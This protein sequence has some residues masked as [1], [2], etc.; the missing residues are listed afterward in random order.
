MARK[1]IETKELFV[2]ML[3]G[4]VL[5]P[6]SFSRYWKNYGSGGSGL[7]GWRPPKKIYYTEGQAKAGLAHIPEAIKDKVEI[8]KF[9]SAGKSCDTAT[10]LQ[11]A[12]E[13][14]A[15]K[16]LAIK[17]RRLRWEEEHIRQQQ[18]D[19]DRRKA[20]LRRAT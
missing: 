3:D 2:L 17:E 13:N 1:P 16:E 11:K 18:A 4:F 6:D 14:K 15:K 7:Y 10:V 5:T 19:L 9:V 12:R 8:H 20:A